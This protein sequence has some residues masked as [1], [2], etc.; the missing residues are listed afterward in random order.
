MVFQKDFL[1]LCLN[2]HSQK[3]TR[4][5]RSFS[6]LV[7]RKVLELVGTAIRIVNFWV[8]IM[9]SIVLSSHETEGTA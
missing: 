5:K 7:L 9:Q 6:F 1:I 8:Q 3:Q 4:E 2:F